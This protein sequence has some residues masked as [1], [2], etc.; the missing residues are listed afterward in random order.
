[1]GTQDS[2]E[3]GTLTVRYNQAGAADPLQIEVRKPNLTLVGVTSPSRPI[4]VPVGKY[5]VRGLSSAGL[6]LTG[7]VEVVGGQQTELWLQPES[8]DVAF[9]APAVKSAA[10]LRS[11][12]TQPAP[13]FESFGVGTD[14][15]VVR[16]FNG[17]VLLGQA[18]ETAVP[19][20]HERP[21]S[22]PDRHLFSIDA[23][24]LCALQ[25]RMADTV[26][27][28]VPPISPRRGCTLDIR[29]IEEGVACQFGISDD[30]SVF[31]DA[32]A[33]GQL[34]AATAAT[35]ATFARDSK[36]LL[37]LAEDLF[38][39]K[40][41]D[42]MGA[43]LSGLGL[44][45]MGELEMLGE[46]TGKLLRGLSWSPD[47]V[48]VRG[49]YLARMGQHGEALNVFLGLEPR[50]LPVFADSLSHV[51]N[52][53][54]MYLRVKDLSYHETEVSRLAQRLQRFSSVSDL[55][56]PYVSYMG[57]DPNEPAGAK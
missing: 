21:P 1:M 19:Q 20:A 49:E 23:G 46:W 4:E 41:A 31:L 9:D 26:V 28:L 30:A 42:P 56:S 11:R 18:V 8:A 17:N 25:V 52:R 51:L 53:L 22:G 29:R 10:S 37:E 38:E 34:D 5:H 27:N 50:G 39:D 6:E 35:Q 24:Q 57:E 36:D 13:E 32:Y 3:K 55:K 14:P 43:I 16:T 45:R 2:R 7:E 54:R 40:L 44:L 33:A 15:V 47:A 12:S 48:C